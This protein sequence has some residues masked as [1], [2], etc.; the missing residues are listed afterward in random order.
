MSHDLTVEINAG[1]LSA[2]DNI[3]LFTNEFHI[4]V[5]VLVITEPD[6]NP[7]EIVQKWGVFVAQ[8]GHQKGELHKVPFERIVKVT[9]KQ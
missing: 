2:D 6:E 1:P 4:D 3:V 8:N 7:V 5:E 9:E